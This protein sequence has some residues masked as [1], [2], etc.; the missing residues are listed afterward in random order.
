MRALTVTAS[1]WVRAREDPRTYSIK[2]PDG[3]NGG[4]GRAMG[5]VG[6]DVRDRMGYLGFLSRT[7]L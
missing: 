1:P 5:G 3:G 4:V 6:R 2:R 7:A